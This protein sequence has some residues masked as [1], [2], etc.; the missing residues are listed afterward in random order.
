LLGN[1]TGRPMPNSNSVFS[2]TMMPFFYAMKP[3]GPSA[4]SLSVN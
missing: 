4:I 3:C 1:N 2:E